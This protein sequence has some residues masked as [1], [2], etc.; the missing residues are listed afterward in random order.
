MKTLEELIGDYAVALLDG[1]TVHTLT[2]QQMERTSA[3]RAAI[4][5]LF[6]DA[7]RTARAEAWDAR[8]EALRRISCADLNVSAAVER[9]LSVICEAALAT[10]AGD[11]PAWRIAR[12]EQIL[13]DVITLDGDSWWGCN[14]PREKLG[15]RT[16]A[17]LD[18][19][20]VP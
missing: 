18:A 2:R 16:D 15:A 10:D 20:K 5:A 8:R 12:L 4:Q 9:W 7:K 13:R 19:G 17:E 14:T 1:N 3:A 11:A 6:S